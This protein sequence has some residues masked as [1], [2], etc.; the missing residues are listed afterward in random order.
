MTSS[1][2]P[3]AF[4][5]LESKNTAATAA[6]KKGSWKQRSSRTCFSP[7]SPGSSESGT[8]LSKDRM[9]DHRSC[10]LRCPH[11]NAHLP[12]IPGLISLFQKLS[13]AVLH[14]PFA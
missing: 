3:F 2:S 13:D 9:H 11:R 12:K 14:H 5:H 6:K 8:M 4:F 7:E 10:S 1:S